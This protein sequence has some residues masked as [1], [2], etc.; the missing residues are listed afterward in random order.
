METASGKATS[1][2]Q[3]AVAAM[4]GGGFYN[5]NSSL[6]AANL[7]SAL[8]LLQAAAESLPISAGRGIVIAD[9]GVSEGRN[10]M[11][12]VAVALDGL[13]QKTSSATS[14]SVAH[15]DLPSNDFTSLFALLDGHGDSYLEGRENV[16]PFAVGR[17]HFGQVLPNASVDLGWS[18]NAVHWMSVNPVLV[19]DHGWA[20]FSKSFA[21]R[22]KVEAQLEQDWLNFL[23]ARSQ[24]L[25]SGGKLVCQFMARGENT[26]GFEYVADA[27]WASVQDVA[28]NGMLD[29]SELLA[30]TA[31]SAARSADQLRA[32]FKDGRFHGLSLADIAIIEAPDPM[33]AAFLEDGDAQKFG[34][35]WANVMRA[36]NGPSFALG[37]KDDGRREAVTDAIYHR[38]AAKLADDPQPARS[39]NVLLS[40]EKQ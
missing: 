24:E 12:P 8:P 14:I 17:S 4:Q 16:F 32:P 26:H 36:A 18:S 3:S 37:M 40:I 38:L 15:I 10:S 34:H 33:Y 22:E 29:E 35:T 28:D 30:M 11:L 2:R 23:R 25:R 7:T 20:I 6:Q 1:P 19:K 31:P 9:Y 13:R 21:A 5:Q 27:F 39:F